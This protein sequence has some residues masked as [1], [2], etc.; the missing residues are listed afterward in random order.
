ME[1]KV[2]RG[3][4]EPLYPKGPRRQ[5]GVESG[6]QEKITRQKFAILLLH[7]TDKTTGLSDMA[8]FAHFGVW[9]HGYGENKC[10]LSAF[11]THPKYTPDPEAKLD[12]KADG[13][14]L[15]NPIV[16]ERQ[17]EEPAQHLG[18]SGSVEP[19][20]VSRRISSHGHQNLVIPEGS[21]P[22]FTPNPNTV[23][24]SPQPG[25][26]RSVVPSVF[27]H[28]P[29]LWGVTLD[30]RMRILLLAQQVT[31]QGWHHSEPGTEFLLLHV[32][33]ME[34]ALLLIVYPDWQTYLPPLMTAF[35]NQRPIET[36]PDSRGNL[37]HEIALLDEG[38]NDAIQEG[39][40]LYQTCATP[41]QKQAS[42]DVGDSN[43]NSSWTQGYRPEYFTFVDLDQF[44]QESE[45]EPAIDPQLC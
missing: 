9:P 32:D 12:A 31:C 36:T 14:S 33:D 35:K 43:S 3:S 37:L 30:A 29:S 6:V 18:E 38:G 34:R 45:P 2:N 1:E 27:R 4:E 10:W 44:Q 25:V 15:E 23:G 24:P 19:A 28:A 16:P 22:Y 7:D 13:Q 11:F 26:S 40:A 42:P 20:M 17:I 21:T 41:Q 5:T 8:P 39:P